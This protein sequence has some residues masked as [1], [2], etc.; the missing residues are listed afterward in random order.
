MNAAKAAVKV[1]QILFPFNSEIN[2]GSLVGAVVVGSFA[3]G[4]IKNAAQ[5]IALGLGVKAAKDW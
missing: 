2:F 4:A 1:A 3:Y 5:F